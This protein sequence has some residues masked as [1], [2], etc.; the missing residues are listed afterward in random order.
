[1]SFRRPGRTI[2]ETER[3]WADWRRTHSAALARSGL[4]EAV[5]RDREHWLDFLEH[6]FLDHHDDS[7]HFTVEQLSLEQQRELRQFLYH[8]LSPDERSSAVVLRR[9]AMT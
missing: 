4:P 6:G 3:E 1:M 9:L 8:I 2:R 7:S 5:L